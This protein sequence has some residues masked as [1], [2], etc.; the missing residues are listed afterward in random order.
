PW[1]PHWTLQA[2]ARRT[3]ARALVHR[4]SRNHDV[5]LSCQPEVVHAYQNT[6]RGRHHAPSFASRRDRTIDV[7]P[8]PAP[9]CVFVCGGSTLLHDPAD[10]AAQAALPVRARVFHALDR[11]LKQGNESAGFRAADAIVFD[12]LHTRSIVVDGYRIDPGKCVTVHGGVDGKVF[13]PPDDRER[14]AARARWGIEPDA[15]VL[16][17]TGRISPEKNLPLLIRSAARI[18]ASKPRVCIVGD[19]PER[20]NMIRLAREEGVEPLVSFV[21]SQSNVRPYLHAADC[22]AFP[23]R[24][25]SFGGSLVEAMACGLPCVVLAP[26][27]ATS[28]NAGEEI[29]GD[30]PCGVMVSS[31]DPGAFA[32]AID[33]L[34]ADPE[35]RRRLGLRAAQ[36]AHERFT[37]SRGGRQLN[38][39]IFRMLN[40]SIVDGPIRGRSCGTGF[41]P[42]GNSKPET[43]N[44]TLAPVC[45]SGM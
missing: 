18:R 3:A 11:R 10:T 23:S 44:S 4:L 13:R 31:N 33:E 34:N 40:E 17:W 19:G 22:F 30:P 2:T 42:V 9:K 6:K 36:R 16:T 15:F 32:R 8:D 5:F 24:S 37:W 43:R 35:R 20:D 28:R 25:E 45:Q 1:M 21:G 41:Q 7:R 12:S 29:L 38:D 27:G 14:A 39:L 26:D